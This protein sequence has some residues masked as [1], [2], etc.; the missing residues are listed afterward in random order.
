MSQTL[1]SE[2]T[3]L[4]VIN[5]PQSASIFL[6]SVKRTRDVPECK[7]F[8]SSVNVP[9]CTYFSQPCKTKYLQRA[10]TPNPRIPT[11]GV[12]RVVEGLRAAVVR[13]AIHA[14]EA[15][16]VMTAYLQLS[17]VLIINIPRKIMNEFIFCTTI[18]MH[19]SYCEETSLSAPK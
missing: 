6:S 14:A 3:K 9:E 18:M 4:E 12:Q 11:E 16:R 15:V 19:G 10:S 2:S 5:L 7:Y 1:G 17:T 8:L 13:A